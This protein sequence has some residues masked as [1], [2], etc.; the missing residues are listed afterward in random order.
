ME[1]MLAGM[2]RL[3]NHFGPLQ[4]AESLPLFTT[5]LP[6]YYYSRVASPFSYFNQGKAELYTPSFQNRFNLA[7]RGSDAPSFAGPEP[8]VLNQMQ[9]LDTKTTLPDDLLVKA[10]RMTMG[11]SLEL[12]VPF[13][14]HLLLEFAARFANG[15]QSQRTGDETHPQAR[16]WESHSPRDH[17]AQEPASRFRSSAGSKMNCVSRFMRYC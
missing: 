16:L 5:A 2:L 17:S 14:D 12:R 3:A 9:Y 8:S 13:L 11:N 10:D 7:F 1:G 4:K 15:L 6:D